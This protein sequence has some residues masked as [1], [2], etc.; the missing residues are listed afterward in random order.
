MRLAVLDDYQNV[1]L[2]LADWS[3][4]ADRAEVTV[5]NDHVCDPDQ[6]LARLAPFDV[7]FVM[8]ERTT[9]PRSVIEQLPRLPMIASAGPFNAAIDMVAAIVV[10]LDERP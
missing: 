1:A 2:Q 10:W 5:F 4:V 9:L 6:P 7:V 8:R 3:A